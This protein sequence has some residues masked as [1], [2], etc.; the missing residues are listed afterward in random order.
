MREPGPLLVTGASGD[1]GVALLRAIL[2]HEPGAS[3]IAHCL[4]GRERLAALLDEA[5]ARD[6]VRI[7][8]ADL[9]MLDGART[10]LAAI[11]EPGELPHRVVHLP[12]LPLTYERFAEADLARFTT[13]VTIQVTSLAALLQVILPEVARRCAADSSAP[14]GKVVAV[15]SS[16]LLGVPPK[17]TAMYAAAKFAQAGLLRALSADYADQRVNINMVA[18]SMVETAFLRAIPAKAVEI[19]AAR[20]PMRRNGQPGDVVPAIEFLLSPAS[21]YITGTNLPITGGIAF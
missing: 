8:G 17:H 13:D 18:P 3:I 1:L 10:L 5:N 19:A 20:H 12:A 4:R 2:Q 11:G 7:I 14:N 9:S 21:D 15:S 16:V 6:R